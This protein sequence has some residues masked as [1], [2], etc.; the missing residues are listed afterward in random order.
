MTRDTTKSKACRVCKIVKPID[1]FYESG[2][3]KDRI[4]QR[5]S[6]CVLESHVPTSKAEKRCVACGIVKSFDCFWNEPKTPTGK[7]GSCAE[8]EHKRVRPVLDEYKEWIDSFKDA[9]CT[10]CGRKYPP[11]VMHWD[12][13]PGTNKLISIGRLKSSKAPKDRVLAELAKCELVCANCHANRTYERQDYFRT[14]D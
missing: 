11:W 5:C 4:N 14:N 7:R 2:R 9:P 12:H 1:Q 10:D 13:L 6:E 3:R 8:C